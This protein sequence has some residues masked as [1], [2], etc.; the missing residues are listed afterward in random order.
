MGEVRIGQIFLWRLGSGLEGE[1]EG[2]GCGGS[3]VGFLKS[4]LWK[5]VKLCIK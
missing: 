3:G 1:G 5:L 4:W 2:F